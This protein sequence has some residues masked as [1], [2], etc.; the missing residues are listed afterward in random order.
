[1]YCQIVLYFHTAVK[2]LLAK[3][4]ISYQVSA[5]LIILILMSSQSFTNANATPGAGNL[6]GTDGQAGNLYTIDKTTGAA[7]LKGNMGFI[8]APS[9]AVDPTTGTMYA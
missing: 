1:M 5:F 2:E 9:L 6:F 3:I 7:T 8:S 4:K